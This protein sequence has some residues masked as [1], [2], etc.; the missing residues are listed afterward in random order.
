MS[1]APSWTAQSSGVWPFSRFAFT[2]APLA[3]SN[4]AISL[5]PQYTVEC[6]GVSP[7]RLATFT[8]APAPISSRAIAVCPW[9]AA[10][11]SAVNPVM[12]PP[13]F[14][15]VPATRCRRTT[16]TR[17]SSAA[18]QIASD[19]GGGAVAQPASQAAASSVG[20]ISFT[21]KIVS[22]SQAL[23]CGHSAWLC[24]TC[25]AWPSASNYSA[26][27]RENRPT[28]CCRCCSRSGTKACLG[29]SGAKAAGLS[30]S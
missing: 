14:T 13:A 27:A 5:C 23:G 10:W 18:S 30:T 21:K 4:P 22:L 29:P 3:I 2:T 12:P 28:S 20:E 8:S 16:S 24:T 9:N 19:G 17:P 7:R 25:R 1:T 26:K 11:C 15:S 6:K